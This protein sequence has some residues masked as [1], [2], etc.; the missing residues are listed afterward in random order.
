[1]GLDPSDIVGKVQH[2]L[3]PNTDYSTQNNL[4]L[5]ASKTISVDGQM[6]LAK[7]AISNER[8]KLVDGGAWIVMES[9]LVL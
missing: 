1:M 5:S 3:K 7:S 8:V 6:S 2:D 4:N 9:L